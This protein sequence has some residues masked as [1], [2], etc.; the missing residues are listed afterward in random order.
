[1]NR[2][3]AGNKRSQE[4]LTLFLIGFFF[5]FTKALGFYEMFFFILMKRLRFQ[6]MILLNKSPG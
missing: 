3:M 2:E 4:E 5:L 6:V 1:M